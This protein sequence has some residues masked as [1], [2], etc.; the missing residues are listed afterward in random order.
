MAMEIDK[1]KKSSNL[2]KWKRLFHSVI[3][4]NAYLKEIDVCGI[5]KELTFT[6]PAILF[7]DSNTFQRRFQLKP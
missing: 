2:C 3:K 7:A 5:N 6:S 1:Y 4:M